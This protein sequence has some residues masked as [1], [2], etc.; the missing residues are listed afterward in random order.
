MV[1]IRTDANKV[2]ATG[3]VMRCLTI[4]DEIIKLGNEVCFIISDNESLKLIEERGF[5]YIIT[6]SKWNAVDSKRE[7]NLLNKYLNPVDIIVVDSYYLKNDYI[8]CMKTICHVATF[9]DMFEERKDAD[10][11]IN[12]NM[13]SKRFDYKARYSG[14]GSKLLL[15]EKYVP[16]RSQFRD[17]N[18][19][20]NVKEDNSHPTVLV[21]CGGCD[22][23][24][25]I[26]DCIGFIKKASVSLFRDIEW[27]IVV[28]NYYPYIE[29]LNNINK[30]NKNVEVLQNVTDMAGMMKK[31]DL[32]ISAASTV[33]YECCVMLIPTLFFVSSDDQRYD[34]EVFSENEMMIYCGDFIKN[35]SVVKEKLL[36]ELDN[37]IHNTK[38]QQIMKTKMKNVI[39]GKGAERIA[40]AICDS[41]Q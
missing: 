3:H 22:N 27:K 14:S 21:M 41:N 32:C 40:I 17:I 19:I 12:Y 37:L 11:I 28:G 35:S 33:L 16:L 36:Y 7:S 15:G 31:C 29:H 5:K 2:I 25:I 9:D 6:N 34:A 24:D 1:Y 13:F 30:E 38:K 20:E 26:C 39:D 8:K 23:R 10:I 18:P 4:A